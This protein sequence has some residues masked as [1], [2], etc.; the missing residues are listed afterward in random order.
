LLRELRSGCVRCQTLTAMQLHDPYAQSLYVAAVVR[1][2]WSRCGATAR[3]LLVA[4]VLLAIPVS[5]AAHAFL[6]RSDP[7]EGTTLNVPPVQVRIWFDGPIEPVFSTIRVENSNRQ[8]VDKGDGRVHPKDHTLLEVSVPP[9]RPGT[10]R[11]FW[12]IIA[13]DGHRKEGDFPFRIK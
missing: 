5:A 2:V 6:N 11:V 12:S 9:L 4:A 8:R 10:Y 1:C 13:R 3:G 7:P